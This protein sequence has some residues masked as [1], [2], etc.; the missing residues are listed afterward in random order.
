MSECDDEA[1]VKVNDGADVIMLQCQLEDRRI[2]GVATGL[3][4]SVN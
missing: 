4:L 1:I 2:S 3:Y